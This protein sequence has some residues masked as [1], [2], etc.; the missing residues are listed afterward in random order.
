MSKGIHQLPLVYFAAQTLCDSL[1]QVLTGLGFD[2]IVLAGDQWL[3]E[4]RDIAY[5]RIVLLLEDH[6]YP[7]DEILSALVL[8]PQLSVFAICH[9]DA[10]CWGT[11]L[12]EL[13]DEF[14]GWPCTEEELSFRLNHIWPSRNPSPTDADE[15]KLIDE[16]TQ[17]N[18][19]GQ[20]PPFVNILKLIKKIA[21][22]DAPLMIEGN[23][24]TGKEMAARA[25]HELGIRK[26]HPFI[27]INCGAIPDDL[28]ENELFGHEKGAYTDAKGDQAGV[29]A[30]ADGG[31]L[32]LD[33]VDAL[34]P[35][36]Q[37]ALLRFLQ[38]HE[39]RPLGSNQARTADVRIIAATNADLSRAVEEKMFRQDLLFR[40]NIMSLLLPDLRDRVGDIEL[41]A[42]FFVNRF[43]VHYGQPEKYLHPSSTRWLLQY[44]WPGNVRE[45]ENLIHRH[46]LLADSPAIYIEDDRSQVKEQK[47]DLFT[48]WWN[49]SHNVSFG[50][51]KARVIAE[52]E[53][54]YLSWL[55]S[56]SNGNVTLAAKRAGK[57]RRAFG[58]LLK[59]H[60]IK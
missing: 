3:V 44:D 30:Q 1:Q 5:P 36:A 27:P 51:A 46:F 38:D 4:S 55:M 31:T 53:A 7:S 9:C 14:V 11:Q 57:E 39:F 2:V 59:K 16:F 10:A 47:D 43:C 22:C 19:I 20:S 56:E 26:E 52:F 49:D 54:R 23:T 35:K 29:I 15:R 17:Y 58:K 41:L 13:C 34:S 33:E 6:Q 12:L 24:G 45:L 28:L 42:K 37:V 48:T 18:L 21:R 40:L 32:F 8:S 60:A 25:I 50:E